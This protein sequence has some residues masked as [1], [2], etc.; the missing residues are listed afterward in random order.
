MN[1]YACYYEDNKGCV[2]LNAKDDEH[3]AWL[4]QAHA[5]LNGARLSDILP[6]DTHH[7]T[8]EASEL[9]GE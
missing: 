7:F 4:G 3:A 6:L 9:Y 8:P 2:V 5:R 1:R